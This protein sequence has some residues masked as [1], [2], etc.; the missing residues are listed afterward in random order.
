MTTSNNHAQ[1][2]PTTHQETRTMAS[3]RD[4]DNKAPASSAPRL[5][6]AQDDFDY[7]EVPA[8]AVTGVSEE[9]RK[10]QVDTHLKVYLTRRNKL[11]AITSEMDRLKKTLG[12]LERQKEE[13]DSAWRLGFIKALGKQSKPM[14]DQLKQKTQWKLEAEQTKEMIAMLEPQAEWLK[15][16]T[17]KARYTLTTQVRGLNELVAFNQLL[18][19]INGLSDTGSLR[20]IAGSVPHLFN[21]I[22]TEI[23]NNDLYMA[24]FQMDVSLKRGTAIYDHLSDD[25]T[26]EVKRKVHLKQMAALGE[27]LMRRL[28]RGVTHTTAVEIPVPLACEALSQEIPG[29][30]AFWPRVKELESRMEY[31]PSLEELDSD[32]AA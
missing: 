12:A 31:V 32:S 4:A 6:K 2:A 3:T 8:I 26:R 5:V 18:D 30:L 9:K 10:E 28:P 19:G 20:A 16:Y 24:T 17:Y 11:D 27:L 7:V 23:C 25:E 14:R 22:E 1:T 13:A 29:R 21:Q 15:L